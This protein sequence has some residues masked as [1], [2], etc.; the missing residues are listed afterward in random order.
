MFGAAIWLLWVLANQVDA[1]SL[2][3]VMVGLF[4]SAFILWL[5]KI[6][7][8]HSIKTAL[9]LVLAYGYSLGNWDFKENIGTKENDSVAWSLEKEIDL[10]D[11]NRS[12]FINFTAAWCITCQVNEAIA[13][14]EDLMEMFVDKDITYLNADWTNRN[15]VIAKE[16]EKYNRS[17]LPVY[18]Y[19]NKNLDEPMVLNELLTEGYLMEIINEN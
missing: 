19:W 1:N 3:I 13:F 14:T 10:R 4:L 9:I 12:Y 5:Q 18:I 6:N 11:N 7:F 15:P 8:K 16:L 2:L 17:G